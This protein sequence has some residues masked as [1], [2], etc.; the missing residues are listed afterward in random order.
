MRVRKHAATGVTLAVA[1]ALAFPAAAAPHAGLVSTDPGAGANLGASPSAIRLTFSEPVQASFSTVRVVDE[2]GREHQVGPPTT[3][4]RSV[5][6]TERVQL[7]PR[8]VYTVRWRTVSA[9]DGHASAGAFVFGVKKAPTG[10]VVET[11][12]APAASRFEMVARWIFLAGLVLLVGAGAAAVGRFGGRTDLRLAAVAWAVAAGGL[13]LL[14]EAQRR[15]AGT[16]VR[17]SR[18]C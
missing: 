15:T 3:P 18:T 13:L 1:A 11:G 16:S 2:R 7:L 14:G 9:V 4:G 6:L 12:A 8:G 10:P 17:T 5:T